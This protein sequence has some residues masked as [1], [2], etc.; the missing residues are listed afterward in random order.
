M[1]T[2]LLVAAL[3]FLYA[4]AT[5]PRIPAG[6]AC[7]T[8][9]ITV[10]DNFH[11]AR[12][13]T[14]TILAPDHLRL[15]IRPE[16]KPPINDSPW[17]AFRIEP[18]QPTNVQVTLRYRG[19][20]HRYKPKFSHDRLSW[21]VI[22]ENDVIARANGRQASLAIELDDRPVY[23]AGQELITTAI[24]EQWTDRIARQTDAA[25]S[26]L[27]ESLK[28]QS[29]RMLTVNDDARDVLFITGRQHPPEVSGAFAFFAFAETLLADTALAREFRHHFRIIAIPLLNP[30]GVSGGNWR[31]NLGGVDLNRDWGPFTQPETQIVR[32]L[33]AD[34]D[35]NGQQIRFFLDFH[36]TKRNVFYT[37]NGDFPTSPPGL[38]NHWL[39][40]SARRVQNYEFENDQNEV[41]EQA[42]SKNYMYK[43]YR[44]P[45]ATYEVGDET[46]RSAT[47]DAAVIFAEELMT[48]LLEQDF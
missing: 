10:T 26:V 39:D 27:G 22:D 14:C 4:C 35:S 5:A 23:V 44:I 24:Y 41:S 19:G 36:S 7:T 17:Y 18:I 21:W 42:N 40:R 33:L 28:G 11:G 47:Q 9:L 25:L 45:T 37:Q 13:G 43:R 48:I 34:I 6:Q 31:N 1:R 46:D 8:E 32:D 2:T 38:M 20:H 15:D 30:D 3:I 29:I 12:R 16:D